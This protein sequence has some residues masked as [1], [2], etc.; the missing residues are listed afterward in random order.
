MLEI[1]LTLRIG[2]E[3][4]FCSAYIGYLNLQ[5]HYFCGI[6]SH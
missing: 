4:A 2:I 1:Y 3:M 5:W 6:Y